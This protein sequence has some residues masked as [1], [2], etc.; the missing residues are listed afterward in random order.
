[1]Y[2][3]MY[4]EVIW[5]TLDLLHYNQMKYCINLCVIFSDKCY[6]S[7]I[8]LLF[9]MYTSCVYYIYFYTFVY[10]SLYCWCFENVFFLYNKHGT[11]RTRQA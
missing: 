11:A 3:V 5:Q 7:K 6:S 4:L 9:T 10:S 2:R 1:M 8:N